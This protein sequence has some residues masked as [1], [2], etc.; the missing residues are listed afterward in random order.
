MS[1]NCIPFQS[2]NGKIR[3]VVRPG[4]CRSKISAGR[5]RK[6]RPLRVPPGKIVQAQA[7]LVQGRSQ[8]AIGRELRISPMT[9]AKI[10]RTENFQNFLKEQQERVFGIVPIALESFRAEVATNGILAHAFLKDLGIIPPPEAIAQFLNTA[11]AKTETGEAFRRYRVT[12]LR[13]NRVPE[14]V[15][16]FWIGHADKT[17][18][19]GYSKVKDDVEFRLLCATNVGLGFVLPAE[20]PTAKCD[21]APSC[22]QT[23]SLSKVS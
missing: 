2:T 3:N 19:D 11:T 13:K 20:T 17:V 7:L 15:L 6:S 5:E 18:T 16:R 8:R 22:T 1:A 23:E 14:D 4:A 10:I 12:H 9:V 21:V